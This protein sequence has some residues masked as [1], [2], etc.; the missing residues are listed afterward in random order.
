MIDADEGPLYE[1]KIAVDDRVF[2]ARIA[3]QG[4]RMEDMAEFI[5]D[6][7]RKKD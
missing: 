2:M 4:A 1:A 7:A 6:M 3:E 5:S